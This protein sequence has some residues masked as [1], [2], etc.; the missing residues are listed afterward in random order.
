ML[1]NFELVHKQ[2]Q[3][4]LDKAIDWFLKSF[5]FRY[6]SEEWQIC[7]LKRKMFMRKAIGYLKEANKILKS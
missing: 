7:R 1:N 6:G 3:F 5:K 2:F 4:Y